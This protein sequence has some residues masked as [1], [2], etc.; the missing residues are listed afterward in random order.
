MPNPYEALF[1]WIFV[2][3]FVCSVLCFWSWKESVEEALRQLSSTLSSL[4]REDVQEKLKRDRYYQAVDDLQ[5][6]FRDRAK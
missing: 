6:E 1:M 5:R 2:L 4:G 3:L